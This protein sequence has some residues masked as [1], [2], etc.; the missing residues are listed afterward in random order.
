MFY[1]L[2]STML[3]FVKEY[4]PTEV[5]VSQ[6]EFSEWLSLEW[7]LEILVTGT[8]PLARFGRAVC[9][10]FRILFPVRGVTHCNLLPSTIIWSHINHTIRYCLTLYF[11]HNHPSFCNNFQLAVSGRFP[12]SELSTLSHILQKPGHLGTSYPPL[13]QRPD[14]LWESI[15]FFSLHF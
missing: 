9:I 8:C 4:L 7:I 1:F 6:F 15:R 2:A 12:H 14:H 3:Q 5:P 10:P 11:S 13:S